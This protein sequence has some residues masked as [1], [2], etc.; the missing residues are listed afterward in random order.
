MPA[1]MSKY[2]ANWPEIRNRILRRAGG[3][4][5]DPRVGARCEKCGVRN[6]DVGRRVDGEFI[7]DAR[8][9]IPEGQDDPFPSYQSAKFYADELNLTAK[10]PY[11]VI[12]L[13]IAHV[14]DPDPQN[15]ADDNL[16]AWCQKCH[17]GHDVEY[18]KR[19]RA[20]TRRAQI[21]QSG[22]GVLI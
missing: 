13:T 7:D 2:P 4:E 18:R 21:V 16:A 20:T 8:E 19:N 11:V 17:N 3:S 5:D 9:Y 22:Q 14:H 6:Y 10:Q 15:V 12:V 1:D